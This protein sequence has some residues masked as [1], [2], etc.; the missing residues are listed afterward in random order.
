MIDKN[1]KSVTLVFE[2]CEALHIPGKV[3]K[4][5]YVGD[6]H[7]TGSG[8][9]LCFDVGKHDY[10]DGWYD[11]NY[12]TDDFDICIDKEFLDKPYNSFMS[13]NELTN[14]E[15]LKRWPDITH[16]KVVNKVKGIKWLKFFK[17]RLRLVW[18]KRDEEFYYTTA[19]YFPT[20]SATFIDSD[21]KER[22]VRDANKWQKMNF[23]EKDNLVEIHIEK[24]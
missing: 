18:P 5:I 6:I 9:N 7:K 23:F 8:A 17:K 3:V 15:R 21:G 19:W 24:E 22:N 13:K 10:S 1:L 12:K 2:N 20:A 4:H 14:F 16:V 11:E